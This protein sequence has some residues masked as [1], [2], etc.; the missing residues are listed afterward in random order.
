MLDR[1]RRDRRAL[2]RIPELQ[3]DLPETQAYLLR[4]LKETGAQIDVLSP[5]GILAF[6]D[7]GKAE[8]AAF[9]SDMDALPILE[10]NRCEYASAH[11]GRMHACGHDGHMAMLLELAR[12]AG[13]HAAR[14]PR[15]LLLI[16]QPAEEGGGGGRGI[17]RSGALEK[18]RAV[19][20]F[21]LHVAPELPAGALAS[22]PGAFFSKS[23]EVHACFRGKSAHAA[24]SQTGRDALAAGADFLLRALE[25]ERTFPTEVLRL[26]KFG[27]FEAGS[28]PNIIAGE[29]TLAGTLRAF[30]EGVFAALQQGLS[31]AAEAVEARWGVSVALSYSESY[32]PLIND[33]AL[34]ARAVRALDGFDYRQLAEP[35]MLS[36][37]F[38]YYLER[39]PGVFFKL[40]L[41][42]G[43]PLHTPRFDFDERAL[44]PGVQALIRLAHMD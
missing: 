9:R 1:L 23:S 6:F 31:A 22:R 35:T 24:E 2:H 10:E 39:V 7:A 13:V 12:Y 32:P 3:F 20:I 27:R 5:S 25:M 29:A 43:I 41:G 19:R 33:A 11:P 40:G 37:D 17:A 36:E 38:S 28:A 34:Y 4:A 42:T 8:T 30:D 44:I 15:N 18:R 16:F 14:L 21:A 26:L